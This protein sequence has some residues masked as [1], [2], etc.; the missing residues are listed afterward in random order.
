MNHN[1]EQCLNTFTIICGCNKLMAVPTVRGA[2]IG[3]AGVNGGGVL[4][5][6]KPRF[7]V[8]EVPSPALTEADVDALPVINE[9]E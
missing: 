3:T 6:D 7:T 8:V 1:V 4:L 9:D 5:S 2:L